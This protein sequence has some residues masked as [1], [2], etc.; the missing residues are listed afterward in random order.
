MKEIWK[1]IKGYE[2]LYQVSNLGRVKSLERYDSYN[3]KVD[4]KILKTKENLGYIYVNLHKN[5]I[6]KGYKVHRL[7]AEAFIPNPDNKPCIDHINTIVTDNR[8]ENLRWCTY[9]ENNRNPI[10]MTK[11]RNKMTGFKHSAE[12]KIKIGLAGLGRITSE[13]T[14]EKHRAKGWKV[15]SF[16]KDGVFY[17]K[18]ASPYYASLELKASKLHISACCNGVRKST[19]G[20]MWKWEKDWNGGNIE[21]YKINR[22]TTTARKTMPAS[23]LENVRKSRMKFKKKVFV[24]D[25]N[26]NFICECSSTRE[27]ARKF[28]TN[29]G[30]V[31]RV[32]NGKIKH[33][34]GFIFKYDKYD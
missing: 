33:S 8:V 9:S 26:N 5:G 34:K 7:V 22:P 1:D 19:G 6:Q 18:F 23:W 15:V 4:E 14:K 11:Y 28:N 21:P 32:C 16:T 17:K 24:Y 12:T 3:K 13:E 31:C 25:L 10:T 2:G 20:F 30:S 27:A 29:S